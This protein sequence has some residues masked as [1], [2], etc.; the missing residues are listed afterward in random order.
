MENSEKK[1]LIVE[2]DVDL[3]NILV[4]GLSLSNYKIMQAGDGEQAVELIVDSLP[5]LILLDLLLPKL[6]GFKVLERLRQYPDKNVAQI[7]VVVLS[8]LWSDKDI[9]RAQ[10]LKVDEYFV[11]A[12]T[13]LE[14]VFNK[15]KVILSNTRNA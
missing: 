12:N 14:D 9:L 7:K 3:R 13:N 10:A 11:K 1:V 8:N 15:V 2:D 6:D 5:D 4:D